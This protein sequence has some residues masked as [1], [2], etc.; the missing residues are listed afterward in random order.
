L[1]SKNLE[2]ITKNLEQITVDTKLKA[3]LTTS[4]VKMHHARGRGR[5]FLSAVVAAVACMSEVVLALREARG[6]GLQAVRH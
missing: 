1:P 5:T 6:Q 4:T 3:E 2:Q